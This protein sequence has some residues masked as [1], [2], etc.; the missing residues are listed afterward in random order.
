MWKYLSQFKFVL[1]LE[2]HTTRQR[3]GK[4]VALWQ[5]LF[6]VLQHPTKFGSMIGWVDEGQGIFE[7]RKSC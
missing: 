1:C 6:Y 3:Q 5:F 2:P 4:Q 7:V